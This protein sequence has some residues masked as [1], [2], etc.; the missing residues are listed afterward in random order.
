MKLEFGFESWYLDFGKVDEKFEIRI[1]GYRVLG[2]GV[3]VLLENM[4]WYK[5]VLDVNFGL[6]CFLV[7]GWYMKVNCYGYVFIDWVEG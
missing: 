4:R 3:L 5:D 6:F 1:L 7:C 2:Y